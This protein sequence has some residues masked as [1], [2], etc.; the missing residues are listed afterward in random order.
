MSD[1]INLLIGFGV[2]AF[3]CAITIYILM[4]WGGS[5]F[6]ENY[7]VDGSPHLGGQGIFFVVI[8]PMLAFV[9]VF[10]GALTIVLSPVLL[11]A[12]LFGR[13]LYRKAQREGQA[14]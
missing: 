7:E 13:W 10:I 3:G 9:A 8:W 2:Y 12:F 5:E 1:Y 14:K 11:P 4:R 6:R